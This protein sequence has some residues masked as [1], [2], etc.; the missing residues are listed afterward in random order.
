VLVV[1]SSG[2]IEFFADGP[3]ADRVQPYLVAA[4]RIVT[5]AVVLYEVYR[6]ARRTGTDPVA[7]SIVAQLEQTQLVPADSAVALTAAELGLEHQ[8][9]VADAFVLATA[10][11][12][13]CDLVTA[14]SDFRGLPGVV[15]IEADDEGQA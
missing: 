15:L 1:D 3:L 10:R 2:W 6:W 13:G 9:A 8:L 11:L 14:D 4:E 7:M 12:R 5:P